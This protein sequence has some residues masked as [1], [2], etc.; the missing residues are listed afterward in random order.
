GR[1]SGEM[2]PFF[3]CVELFLKWIEKRISEYHT[4]LTRNAIF[5]K[6]TAGMGIL[7]PEMA[8]SYGC[9]GPVLRGS[10]VDYDLRRDGE[11]IY[12]RM[13]QGDSFEIPVAPFAK[14]AP[15]EV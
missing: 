1:P 5:I 7:T 10:G 8:V 15:C 4:L 6:R 9:T 11:A 3:D 2:M 12:T 14:V 13:Y